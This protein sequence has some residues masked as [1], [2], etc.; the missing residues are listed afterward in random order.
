MFFFLWFVLFTL[1]SYKIHD[2]ILAPISVAL[3]VEPELENVV[4]KLAAESSL[5][6]VLPLLVHNLEGDVLVRGA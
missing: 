2:I 5:V 1:R 4:M 6:A 3:E